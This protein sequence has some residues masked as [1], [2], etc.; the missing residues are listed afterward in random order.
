MKDSKTLK[1]ALKSKLGKKELELVNRSFDIIGDIAILDIPEELTPKQ[2]RI[3]NTVLNLFKNVKVVAKRAGIHEGEFRLMQLEVIAGENRKETI[4]KENDV[5]ILLDV[6]RVYFSPRSVTER[7]RVAKLVQPGE[8]VLV[9]FSGCGPFPLVI[10]KHSKAKRIV[11]IELNPVAHDYALRNIAFNKFRNMEMLLGDV[12]EVVPKL[13]KFDRIVMPLP[14]TGEEF[15]DVAFAAGK[16]NT[17]IHFYDFS[18]EKDFP[19]QSIGK[20]GAACKKA[21][22]KFKVLESVKCGAYAPYVYRVCID[23]KLL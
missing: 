8:E 10:A 13:G 15:L 3:G 12:R 18:Q 14:K 20:V 21:N 4:H 1:D 23:F 2:S 7:M 5:R 6:E 19:G 22:L 11:G 16:K 17:V 9:M